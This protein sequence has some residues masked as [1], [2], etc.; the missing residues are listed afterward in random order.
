MLIEQTDFVAITSQDAERSRAFYGETLSLRQDE[1]AQYEFWAGDTC[2]A[3]WEPEK[4]GREFQPTK[5]S[6]VA[7]HVADVGAARAEL[8]AKGVGFLGETID[9]GVCHMALFED[10][11]GTDLML[12]DRS[13]PHE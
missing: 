3:I 2:L 11:D 5:Y 10:P 7:F 13:A 6:P 9:T 8:E 12:H 1:R 4:L